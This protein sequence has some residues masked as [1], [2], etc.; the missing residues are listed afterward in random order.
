[1]NRRH[2]ITGCCGCLAAGAAWGQGWQAPAR[3][4]RPD[5]AS[6]EGGLWAMMDREETRL[7]RS[8]FALRDPDLQKYVSEMCCRLGG[9]HCPD[10]RV[11]LV[12]TPYFN[13]FMAPNGWMQVWSGLLLRVDNE[14]Q[15]AAVLGHEIGHYLGRHSVE[16]LREAKS[17]SAFAQVLGLFGVAGLVGQL[18]V[19]AGMYAYGRD[20]ERDADRIGAI[21][22]RG[23]GYDI[24]EAS[25]VWANLQAEVKANPDASRPSILFST[26]PPEAEREQA[27]ARLAGESPGGVNNEEEWRKR[28]APFLREWLHDEVMRRQP[29]ETLAL[30]SRKMALAPQN[31]DYVF[32]RGETCRLRA[33]DGDL[34]AAIADFRS[35]VALGNEPPETHRGMGMI[36]RKQERLA[37]ARASFLR[38]LELAPQAAD[39]AMIRSYLE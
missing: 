25:R 7:R 33:R 23:A 11:Q 16:Q 32:S 12:R 21:L 28:T 20:H 6:D 38:Y 34:D 10:V 19:V 9:E 27:L 18:G 35:A 31:A 2:F 29:E 17:R 14:A 15:L 8:P 37:D 39:A 1:M 24:A 22:M 5:L 3:F 4:A 26:H 13:A 36:F 30:L